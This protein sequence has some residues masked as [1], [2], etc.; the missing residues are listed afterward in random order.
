MNRK[1]FTLIEL[2]VV[3]AIIG[4]L[5]AVGVVAYNGYTTSAKIAVAK[6]NQKSIAKYLNAESMRCKLDSSVQIL[7][8]NY[9]CTTL[10]NTLNS[11]GNPGGALANAIVK[12][13]SGN[14]KN[15]YGANHPPIGDDAAQTAGWGGPRDL[16]YTRI[17][18]RGAKIFVHTCFKL[19]CGGNYDPNTNPN[20][21]VTM[22]NFN[23]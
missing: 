6:A 10:Y 21:I 23:E 14:F 5:A 7:D 12:S 22:V 16:G 1:A 19:D 9:S 11:G 8:G 20:R 3:V 17:D 2:L 13:L 15:P 4:I 18:P